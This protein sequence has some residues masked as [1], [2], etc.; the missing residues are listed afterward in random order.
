MGAWGSG[1]FENDDASD[2]VWELEDDE[3]GSVVIAALSEIVDTEIDGEIE[4]PEASNAI[5][6][7]EI[8]AAARGHH[9]AELPSEAREWIRVNAG[10][11]DSSWLALAA[12][13][14]ERIAIDSELKEL[15]DEAQSSEWS[16]YV[17]DLLSRLR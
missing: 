13:A 5:A 6:A 4:A 10:L 12:G 8:V 15:W 9:R 17:A 1:P 14:V 3:N 16:E 2:W 7:A 11:V